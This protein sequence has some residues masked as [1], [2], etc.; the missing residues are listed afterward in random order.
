MAESIDLRWRPR[1]TTLHGERVM[2]MDIDIDDAAPA[3]LKNG[4]APRAIVNGGGVCGCGARMELPDRAARR[5]AARQGRVIAVDVKHD[6]DC[7]ALLHG[8]LPIDLG[9]WSE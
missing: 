1:E 2:V 4:L 9:R 5:R 6:A 3:D 8:W 7:P